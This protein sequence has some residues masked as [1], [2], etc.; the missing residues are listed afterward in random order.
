MVFICLIGLIAVGG[1]ALAASHFSHSSSQYQPSFTTQTF[2]P[3]PTQT[4]VSTSAQTSISDIRGTYYGSYQLLS[5]SSSHPMTLDITRQ[6]QQDFGGT[7]TLGSGDYSIQNG[8]VDTSGTIRFSIDVTDSAGNQFT[9]KF[10][11][12]AQSDGGWSG[13]FYDIDEQGKWYVY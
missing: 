10:T 3:S 2:I 6:N 1:I 4:S 11:G 12:T 5:S 8:T 7:C 13:S 9:V